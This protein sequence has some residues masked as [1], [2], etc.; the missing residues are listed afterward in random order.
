MVMRYVYS[1]HDK[2]L[3]MIWNESKKKLNESS[4]SCMSNQVCNY[5]IG[6][7]GRATIP[8]SLYLQ[9]ELEAP[10]KGNVW[11]QWKSI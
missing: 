9:T 4:L 5:L 6:N 8:I 1:Y 7:E 2:A 10:R 11:L 3:I